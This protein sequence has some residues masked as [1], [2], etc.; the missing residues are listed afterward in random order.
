MGARERRHYWGVLAE[1]EDADALCAAIRRCR[2]TGYRYVDAYTPFP[3]DAVT[4]AL[5]CRDRVLP[6][7]AL[8]GALLGGGGGLALVYYLNVVDYPLNVGGRPLAAWTAFA[9]PAFECLVLGAALAAVF[10]MIWRNGLPRLHHPVF[11]AEGF[12]RATQDR[13]FLS[14]ESRDPK[15]VL[16]RTSAFLERS[17]ARNVVAVPL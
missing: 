2:K 5:D 8:L 13:F 11:D 12:E 1:Y 15:F 6:Y 14:I 17:G 9:V 4:E 3:V 10:G 16:G 7:L